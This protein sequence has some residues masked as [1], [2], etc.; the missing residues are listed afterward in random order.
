MVNKSHIRADPLRPRFAASTA[1][2]IVKLLDSKKSV[3]MVEKIMLGLKEKGVGQ[4]RL[5][6]RT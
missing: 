4:A 1:M 6:T 5:D 2:T 3:I